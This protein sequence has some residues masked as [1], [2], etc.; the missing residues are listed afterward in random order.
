MSERKINLEEIYNQ[1]VEKEFEGDE[2]AI[3]I[4]KAT[5]AEIDLLAMKEACRQALELAAENAEIDFELQPFSSDFA[6]VI[7]KQSILDTI[8]LIE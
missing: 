2:Q 3:R 8:N 7:N 1:V 6:S 4:Y 5:R